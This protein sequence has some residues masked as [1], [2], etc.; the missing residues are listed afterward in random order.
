MLMNVRLMTQLVFLK[1]FIIIL[2][3][4]CVHVCMQECVH[5]YLWMPGDG[6]TFPGSGVTVGFKTQKWVL[7]T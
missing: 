1:D 3:F 2:L 4:V 7:G 5:G 6:V